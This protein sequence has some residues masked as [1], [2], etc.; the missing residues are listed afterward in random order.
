MLTDARECPDQPAYTLDHVRESCLHKYGYFFFRLMRQSSTFIRDMC[1]PKIPESVKFKDTINYFSFI[2]FW[3]F[4]H[5]FIGKTCFYL[6]SIGESVNQTRHFSMFQQF[7]YFKCSYK[8][9]VC[10]HLEIPLNEEN[11]QKQVSVTHAIV[12]MMQT[13]GFFL[14]I[15]LLVIRVNVIGKFHQTRRI[16]KP[17]SHS[18]SGMQQ[19]C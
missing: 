14:L 9:L 13:R 4:D 12:A 7:H 16:V 1:F 18:L 15:L 17:L 8:Q 2:Y 19:L 5:S 6:I 10:Q 3:N 11:S